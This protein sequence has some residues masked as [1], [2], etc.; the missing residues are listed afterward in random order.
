MRLKAMRC[1]VLVALLDPRRDGRHQV[2]PAGLAYGRD[3]AIP[4]GR[5]VAQGEGAGAALGLS[6]GDVV[7]LVRDDGAAIEWQGMRLQ[8][9]TVVCS[10]CGALSA[11]QPVLAVVRDGQLVD[12]RGR[13]LITPEVQ[14]Q[15]TLAQ[16]AHD[17]YERTDEREVR[18]GTHPALG[19]RCWYPERAGHTLRWA[20]EVLTS[21]RT[22]E[23]C[24]GHPED[25]VA[26]LV[27]VGLSARPDRRGWRPRQGEVLCVAS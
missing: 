6:L 24:R 5:V 15:T 18:E 9:L 23:G 17:G 8:R 12:V 3:V 11:A 13:V 25:E 1:D 19:W 21:L 20:R 10:R 16:V 22:D 27:R 7:C 4:F 14:V 2:T 26:A